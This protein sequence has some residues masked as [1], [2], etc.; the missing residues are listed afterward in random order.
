MPKNILNIR[1]NFEM[2]EAMKHNRWEL[3]DL[4]AE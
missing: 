3:H 2:E 1:I 4:P